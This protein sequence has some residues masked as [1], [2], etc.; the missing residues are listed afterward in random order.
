MRMYVYACI[1]VFCFHFSVRKSI[2]DIDEDHCASLC[3][4]FRW[5]DENMRDRRRP[6]RVLWTPC[7]TV[8]YRWDPFADRDGTA[9]LGR[10]MHVFASLS[11][12]GKINRLLSL[13]EDCCPLRKHETFPSDARGI[14]K[15][16]RSC[17]DDMKSGHCAKT[18]KESN[19][20]SSR[21]R[22]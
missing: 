14:R 8:A 10:S 19:V 9:Q 12:L 22:K 13:H 16:G 15:N 6:L 18:L 3:L 7:Q 21:C 1:L 4:F 11:D 5:T 20:F 2:A 17:F